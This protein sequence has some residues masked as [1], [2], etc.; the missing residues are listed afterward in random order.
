MV[1]GGNHLLVSG[2]G[3]WCLIPA[4]DLPTHTTWQV[5]VFLWY[6]PFIL[7]TSRILHVGLS[8]SPCF[9]NQ[10]ITLV[11]LARHADQWCSS[12]WQVHRWK[13]SHIQWKKPTQTSI[14]IMALKGNMLL[15]N[16]WMGENRSMKISVLNR[17][18]FWWC[19][20][21]TMQ[22]TWLRN[23]DVCG[24]LLIG[25]IVTLFRP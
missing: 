25:T 3:L 19:S 13:L 2:G 17:T 16:H 14:F 24:H 23:S 12:G 4:S 8:A 9:L 5:C 15:Y 6:H 7:L 11:I 22:F 1:Q 21:W 18:A 20:A 10:P